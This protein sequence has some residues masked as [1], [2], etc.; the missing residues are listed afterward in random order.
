MGD[1]TAQADFWPSWIDEAI[2]EAQVW[3]ARYPAQLSR[4][5]GPSFPLMQSSSALLD[6]LTQRVGSR[7]LVFVCHSLGGLVV[8]Q[9]LR[10]TSDSHASANAARLGRNVAGIV[11]LG[12]PHQGVLVAGL[13]KSLVGVLGAIG[14]LSGLTDSAAE[15]AKE[16]VYLEDLGNW[17][18]SIVASRHLEVRVYTETLPTKGSMIVDNHSANPGLVGVSPIPMALNHF[19]LAGPRQRGDQI[20]DAVINLAREVVSQQTALTNAANSDGV[21]MQIGILRTDNSQWMHGI[22]NVVQYTSREFQS[23]LELDYEL[24]YLR[25]SEQAA[26]FIR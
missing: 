19:E 3:T 17:F 22:D 25:N 23:H 26:P 20:S 11:F 16:N 5:F 6:R 18:R 13:A 2:P 4:W 24:G 15:L 10:A 7:P 9:I 21:A 8:K 1:R 14:Q 12:T